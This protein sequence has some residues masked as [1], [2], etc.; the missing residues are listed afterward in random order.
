METTNL[1]LNDNKWH[2]VQVTRVDR[3]LTVTIDDGAARRKYLSLLL[4]FF[5]SLFVSVCLFV[6]LFLS[7]PKQFRPKQMSSARVILS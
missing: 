7:L 5:P 3:S 2:K 6:C 4:C 1:K